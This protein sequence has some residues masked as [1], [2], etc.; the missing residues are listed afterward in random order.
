MNTFF[1]KHY[2]LVTYC[3]IAIVGIAWITIQT[4]L[5]GSDRGDETLVESPDKV[6]ET[7]E[8][9]SA[10]D[11]TS[12]EVT[13]APVSTTDESIT[14]LPDSQVDTSLDF[15]PY[16]TTFFPGDEEDEDI[17]N[18]EDDFLESPPTEYVVPD[19]ETDDTKEPGKAPFDL[20]LANVNESL[21]VRTGPGENYEIIA[22][23]RPDS[24]ARV[25]E[26][27]EEWSKIESGDIVGYA[28]NRYLITGDKALETIKTKSRLTITVTEKLINIRKEPGTQYEI[29]RHAEMDEVFE[30]VPDKS[31]SDWFAIV[32]DDGT[33]AYVATTLAH[34]TADMKSIDSLTPVG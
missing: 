4:P 32:Y 22:K 11:T 14:P 9:I 1:R 2:H 24:C 10:S 15:D 23:F 27:L 31:N 34:V 33:T 20:C 30:Y 26:T 7:G 21:N 12:Q 16:E 19:P 17:D 28:N 6:P 25:I 29:L 3:F 13:S 5:Y 8:A 18:P